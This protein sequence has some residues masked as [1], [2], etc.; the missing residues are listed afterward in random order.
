M[1]FFVLPFGTALCSYWIKK[2]FPI[3]NQ[4]IRDLVREGNSLHMEGRAGVDPLT[5]RMMHPLSLNETEEEEQWRL[6]HFFLHQQQQLKEGG[7]LAADQLLQRMKMLV[8]YNTLV[9]IIC[10]ILV[11]VGF[12]LGWIEGRE[13]AWLVTLSALVAG[14][15]FSFLITNIARL[16]MALKLKETPV[17]PAVLNKLLDHYAGRS[18]PLG[19]VSLAHM[20]KEE[21]SRGCCNKAKFKKVFPA[22][23]P[24]KYEEGG[25][26]RR[27]SIN[28]TAISESHGAGLSE[29]NQKEAWT[30]KS[31][32]NSS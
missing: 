4:S 19:E 1:V 31:V 24:S 27:V 8:L 2:K 18:F 30:A 7:H 10:L 29:V 26:A 6:D 9:L 12:N 25:R 13:W 20:Q 5:G 21:Q 16:R 17:D 23:G 15:D 28:V 14:I 3:K 11:I 22:T 32:A